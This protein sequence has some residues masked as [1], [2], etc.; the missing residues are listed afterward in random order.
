MSDGAKRYHLLDEIRGFAILCMVFFHG[1]YLMATVF[2]WGIG[3][4]LLNFFMPAEPFFA[5]AF[6]LMSGISSRL[7]KNNALRGA[8]LLWIAVGLTIVT[9]GLQL[10]GVNGVVIWFGILHLLSV[11]MLFYAATEK[12]LNK[13]PPVILV[14]L[15]IVLFVLTY[16][17]ED[18]YLGFGNFIWQLPTTIKFN[19]QLFPFGVT[20]PGFFSADYF[21]ILPWLF[22]FVAGT[23]LGKPFGEGKVPA[24]FSCRHLSLFAFCGRHSLIIYLAHQP[25][26]YGLF[27]LVDK[28]I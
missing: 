26:L 16:H 28:I 23:A 22:M 24:F 21:P 17:I 10:M 14:P 9:Y 13:I 15:C 12:V 1:F 18:G 20:A 5:A 27:F 8:K 11:S 2:G 3:D 6:V 19:R 4:T 7:S 25:V